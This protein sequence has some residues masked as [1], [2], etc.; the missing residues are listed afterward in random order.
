MYWFYQ[1][2][3]GKRLVV[4]MEGINTF[5]APYL[6]QAA[7]CDLIWFR[8]IGLRFTR[9]NKSGVKNLLWTSVPK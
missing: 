5:N 4:V 8:G 2:F 7:L 6:N 1:T 3:E 9:M